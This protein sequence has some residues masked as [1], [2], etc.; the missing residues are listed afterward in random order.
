MG[1]SPGRATPSHR[2]APLAGRP[3]LTAAELLQCPACGTSLAGDVESCPKCHLSDALFDAVREAAGPLTSSDPAAL[4]T[5]GEILAAVDLTAPAA[6]TPPT[7]LLTRS[8]RLPSLRPAPAVEP[9]DVAL[10]APPLGELQELPGLPSGRTE[11]ELDRK[12]E[13][14]FHLGRR[15]GLDF[16]DFE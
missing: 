6:A 4:K 12:I 7:A 11:E 16:S 8:P 9:E 10:D 3:P 2:T 15:L 5:I 13:E 14:Y 1:S